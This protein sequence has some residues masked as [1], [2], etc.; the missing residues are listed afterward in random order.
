METIDELK[1]IKLEKMLIIFEEVF[2]SSNGTNVK[3]HFEVFRDFLIK[4]VN[5]IAKRKEP[6]QDQYQEKL[7]SNVIH[8]AIRMIKNLNR[9]ADMN[10]DPDFFFETQ[11]FLI[12]LMPFGHHLGINKLYTLANNEV[13]YVEEKESFEGIS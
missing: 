1:L 11:K 3:I 9:K 2:E 4:Q 6:N 8:Y 7:I 5:I 13:Q 12:H 10:I